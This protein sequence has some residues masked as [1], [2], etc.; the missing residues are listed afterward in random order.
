MLQLVVVGF[1]VAVVGKVGD[2]EALLAPVLEDF[3][4][5]IGRVAR[6]DEAW[7]DIVPTEMHLLDGRPS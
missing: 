1:V 3:R 6:D 5:E 7:K 4:V 2:L